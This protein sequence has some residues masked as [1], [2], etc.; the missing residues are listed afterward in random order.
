MFKKADHLY[1]WLRSDLYLHAD[2]LF[3]KQYFETRVMHSL[4]SKLYTK[5]VLKIS[6]LLSK[7]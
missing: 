1:T 4:L 3:T 6:F 7:L 2:Q 5:S